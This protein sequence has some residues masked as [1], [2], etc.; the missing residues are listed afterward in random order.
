MDLEAGQ[1]VED[2]YEVLRLA[3]S[4]EWHQLYE[5]V[6]RSS[7]DRLGLKILDQAAARNAKRREDFL[8]QIQVARKLEHRNLLAVVGQGEH[9]GSPYLLTEHAPGESLAALLE[10]QGRIGSQELMPIAAA[11]CSALS[12]LHEQGI[13]H[14]DIRPDALVLGADGRWKLRD[15]E[16]ARDV[17]VQQTIALPGGAPPYRS[18]E[19]LLGRA[20]DARSDIYSAG[21]VMFHALTGSRPLDGVDVISR[22]MQP[23]PKVRALAEDCPPELAAAIERCLEAEAGQRFGSVQE[24]A[25][26]LGGVPGWGAQQGVAPAEP[27]P[28]LEPAPE[29]LPDSAEPEPEFKPEREP[30][31]IR[32]PEPEPVVEEPAP[33]EKAAESKPPPAPQRKRRRLTESIGAEPGRTTQVVATLQQILLRLQAMRE[34][35]LYHAPLSPDT[36]WISD[37]DSAIEIDA[38]PPPDPGQ[39]VAIRQPKYHAPEWLLEAPRKGPEIERADVYALGFIAYEWLAGRDGFQQVFPHDDSAQPMMAWMRWQSDASAVAPPLGENRSWVPRALS[40]LVGK[41]I[42]K[43]PAEAI[44]AYRDAAEALAKVLAQVEDTRHVTA[45]PPKPAPGVEGEGGRP[46]WRKIAAAGAV[47]AAAVAAWWFLAGTLPAS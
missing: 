11:L 32:E 23:P 3:G 2:R 7:G 42:A 10:R 28:A 35:D 41:M 40:D 34:Q 38:A 25:Q 20:L 22:F 29:A 16:M 47:V 14:R 8:R 30:E 46:M 45:A 39:T 13:I 17:G 26:A 24:L 33:A 27:E 31:P 36:I 6:D 43:N 44:I 37:K 19:Q 1:L 12:F 4:G 21:A 5:V 15:F 9:Q 18:P